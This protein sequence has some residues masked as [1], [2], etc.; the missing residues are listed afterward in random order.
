MPEM[1]SSTYFFLVFNLYLNNF[2][3]GGDLTTNC[4]YYELNY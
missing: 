2:D 3:N 4:L 1:S